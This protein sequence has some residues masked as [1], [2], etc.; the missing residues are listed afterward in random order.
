MSVS[1]TTFN[2]SNG[3][4]EFEK[5]LKIYIDRRTEAK[6]HL[7][8]LEAGLEEQRKKLEQTEKER[9][10]SIAKMQD[11]IGKGEDDP[12]ID[13]D[14]VSLKHDAEHLGEIISILEKSVSDAKVKVEEANKKLASGLLELLSPIRQERLNKVQTEIDAALQDALE[15][16]RFVEKTMKDLDVSL[17]SYAITA[18][19]VM[20][21]DIGQ[22]LTPN[23]KDILGL[24]W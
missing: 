15:Y 5:G 20:R 19:L 1:N 7:L 14:I 21:I 2:E 24:R 12:K 4:K 8:N 10:S 22:G 23:E 3:I 16:I 9:A 6:Q 17:P 11:A 18:L 13:G